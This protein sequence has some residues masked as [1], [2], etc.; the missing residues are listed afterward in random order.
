MLDAGINV[1]FPSFNFPWQH[2]YARVSEQIFGLK[3]RVEWSSALHLTQ[4]IV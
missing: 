4:R 2:A 1:E 3:M